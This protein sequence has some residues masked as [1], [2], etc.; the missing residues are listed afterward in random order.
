[1]NQYPCV[2][3]LAID[4][5]L[6]GE[7]V[8]EGFVEHITTC[9]RCRQRV[10]AL[11]QDAMQGRDA[12]PELPFSGSAPS[13]G[14]RWVGLVVAA[15]GLLLAVALVQT[16]VRRDAAEPV[17]VATTRTKG[18]PHLSIFV[19]RDARMFAL[20]ATPLQA[21]DALAFS[22]TSVNE[23]AFALFDVDAG[24]VTRIHPAGKDTVQLDA[25]VDVDLGLAV[26]FDGSRSQESIVAVFCAQSVSMDVLER[27]LAS[28]ALLPS[29]CMT[30]S[31]SLPKG[32]AP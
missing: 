32:R 24:E 26:E 1:M 21:G 28:Q 8:D 16:L 22:Y 29:G 10:D 17:R 20:D 2:S 7:S 30:Q 15:A 14:T 9:A 13:S 5:Y 31:I 27:A 25:G 3:D 6:A 23:T 19:R 11:R 4:R 12:L 18:R